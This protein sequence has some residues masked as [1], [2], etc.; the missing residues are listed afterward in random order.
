M[1][2]PDQEHDDDRDRIEPQRV[3][4]VEVETGPEDHH[5]D[6]TG[7]SDEEI[8]IRVR[9]P[10]EDRVLSTLDALKV[11]TADGLIP[12]SNFITRQPVAKLGQ[13][14][15]I[16]QER[17]FDVKADVAPG[18]VR[19]VGADGPVGVAR[20]GLVGDGAVVGDLRE[21]AAADGNHNSHTGAR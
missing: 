19:L 9:L 11:R 4:R 6:D 13:I 2:A 1:A 17:F 12:L 8:E 5:V 21:H 7:D 20:E 16:D 10:Q 18:L 15:R 3:D 14:D